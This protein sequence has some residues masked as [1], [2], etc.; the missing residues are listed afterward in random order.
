MRAELQ[1][2]ADIGLLEYIE[3]LPTAGARR[4][5]MAVVHRHEMA[6]AAAA[7]WMP[8]AEEALHTLHRAGLR[9]GIVTRNSREAARLTMERLGMPAI[10]LKAR[11]D[12]APKPDPE[13]LLSL[14]AA[15]A[16]RPAHCAYVGD[17]RFDIEAAER[18]GM[19]PVLYAPGGRAAPEEA[20]RSHLLTDFRHLVAWAAGPA[21]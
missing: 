17:F 9:T 10:P 2:P 1:A 3:G 18:A 15:W 11:E 14:A 5:A 4:S 7:T 20:A 16:L 12:A 21:P 19:T 8:G 13:A 6:G